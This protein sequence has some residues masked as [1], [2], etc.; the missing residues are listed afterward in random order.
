MKNLFKRI[1]ELSNVNY[2]TTV[3]L[4]TRNGQSENKVKKTILV[5]MASK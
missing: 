2:K 1:N 4:Y 5:T 3:F